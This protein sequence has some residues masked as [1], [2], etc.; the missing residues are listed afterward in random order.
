MPRLVL[1]GLIEALLDLG[2]DMRSDGAELDELA[3]MGVHLADL[4]LN[5][6]PILNRRL[7]AR[8]SLAGAPALFSGCSI[9]AQSAGFWV[10]SV[11]QNSGVNPPFGV[12]IELVGTT[13]G[14]VVLTPINWNI[15]GTETGQVRNANQGNDFLRSTL[16][17]FPALPLNAPWVVTSALESS[18]FFPLWVPPGSFFNVA[19][20][21]ANTAIDCSIALQIPSNLTVVS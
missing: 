21:A 6:K 5:Y 14:S 3:A 13:F 20:L 18:R 2:V 8:V 15:Y 17:Q 4:S 16:G 12:G 7:H 19:T 1:P 9:A 10:L 11:V